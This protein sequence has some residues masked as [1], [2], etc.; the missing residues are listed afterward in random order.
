MKEGKHVEKRGG[1]SG[2]GGGGAARVR[3]ACGEERMRNRQRKVVKNKVNK[4]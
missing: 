1:K 2:K 4:Q 3:T